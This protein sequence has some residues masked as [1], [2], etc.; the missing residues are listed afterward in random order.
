M[1]NY[2][3]YDYRG[4]LG[5][6]LFGIYASLSYAIK[7]GKQPIFKY[8]IQSPSITPRNTYWDTIF[9]ELSTYNETET[10]IEWTRINDYQHPDI[11]RNLP[12]KNI[13]LDGYFQHYIYFMDVL[14][15]INKQLNISQYRETV[16][17]QYSNYISDSWYTIGIHFRLGDYKHLQQHHPLLP[18]S[19]YINALRHVI[20]SINLPIKLKLLVFCEKEDMLDVTSRMNSISN[21]VETSVDYTIVTDLKTDIEECF[22]ISLCDSIIVA[23]STFS[24]WSGI[25][26]GHSNVT[27]PYKWFHTETPNG[28]K[29]P[30]WKVISY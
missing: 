25:F 2:I 24:W 4:G 9:K 21:E 6:Q 5:N 27:I 30:N 10:T 8:S 3:T 14:P 15:I 18:N 28:Y 1:K 7:Y 13:M 19:Y 29:V 23:N 22:L 16:K 26:S 12:D 11:I 17:K 20:S